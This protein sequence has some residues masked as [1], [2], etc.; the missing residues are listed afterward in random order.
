MGA[1]D[2]INQ[3]RQE[4]LS[5]PAVASE[6]PQIAEPRFMVQIKI[7]GPNKRSGT[8]ITVWQIDKGQDAPRLITNYLKV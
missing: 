4:L 3:I 1:Q 2:V 5:T 8:L 6:R 7:I